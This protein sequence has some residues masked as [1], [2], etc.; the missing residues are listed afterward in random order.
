VIKYATE[1]YLQTDRSDL[2]LELTEQLKP[3]A[4]FEKQP[5]FYMRRFTWYVLVHFLTLY[6]VAVSGNFL[7]C[8][9]MISIDAVYIL[10]LGFIGHDLAHGCVAN[11]MFY[12]G[13]LGEF[14]WS[15]FLGL[16]KEFWDQ[17]HNLHH[18][19]TNIANPGRGDPDIETP[20]F[21][22]GVQQIEA[23]G[24]RLSRVLVGYQH[25][26][27]WMALS[28]LVFGLAYESVVFLITE[29]FKGRPLTVRSNKG[30]VLSV[31]VS[32]Y[33][34]N[35]WPLFLNK[36]LWM[37]VILLLYK[38]MAAGFV[39]GFV[40]ALNHVGL[41]T[42]S[43]ETAV[44]R[45]TLQTYTTRNIS[46]RFGRWFW[47]V[48]A[49][50]TEHH[51]WPGISWHKLPIAA[52]VTKKFCAERGIIYNEEGVLTSLSDSVGSLRHLSRQ[53]ILAGRPNP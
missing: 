13:Y 30:L 40:F 31:I 2:F 10:R 32:G 42:L 24:S 23:P 18:R 5:M 8:A 26:L 16:S 29:T 52:A 48:L 27:Y 6:A 28:L 47:G 19:Y 17:K 3:H 41:P 49:Y 39:I 45:L 1:E 25:V 7:W 15:F 36:P 46:G 9:L 44:D 38:Y 34:I 37:G 21:V 12:R 20:P 14:V 51:L 53:A 35:N 4:C 43:G 22:M 33:L 50:Q 11:T